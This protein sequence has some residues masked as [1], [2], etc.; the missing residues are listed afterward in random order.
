VR[1]VLPTYGYPLWFLSGAAFAFGA[2]L[3]SFLN[4]VIARV[5]MGESVAWPGSHCRACKKPIPARAN[6][7][8]L[9]WALLRGRCAECLSPFSVRYALVE[10]GFALVCALA[11][12]RHGVSMPAAREML[13]MALLVAL[14]GTDLDHWLLP[15]EITWPGIAAGLLLGAAEGTGAMVWK[16]LAAAVGYT[17]LALV[18]FVGERVFKKEAVGGGDPWLFALIGAFLGLRALPAVLLLASM[19]GTVI[20]LAMIA[21]RRRSEAMEG[22]ETAAPNG[23]EAPSEELAREGGA[24]GEEEGEWKPDPTAI[25]FGPFL[26]LGAAE[27]LYFSRLPQALFPWPF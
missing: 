4:V 18:G 9:S 22:E 26:A 14:T 2:V 8:I 6:I 20:G 21:A 11:I 1:D 12:A 23:P 19:Q 10:L 15:H 27:V 24:E 3:G 25:P 7:P 13:L 17:A 5:P 16:L